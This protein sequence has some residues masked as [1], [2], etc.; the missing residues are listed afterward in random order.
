MASLSLCGQNKCTGHT[1]EGEHESDDDRRARG[2]T[3][4]A[5][6]AREGREL[7]VVRISLGLGSD[8]ADVWRVI[9]FVERV[10]VGGEVSGVSVPA[11]THAD[12]QR[13]SSVLMPL[14]DTSDWNQDGQSGWAVGQ[15][16]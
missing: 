11:P 7:G 13:S 9:R 3:L 5:I 2:V 8:W 6:E 10:V 16:I 12:V 1:V 15:A 14:S 4:D